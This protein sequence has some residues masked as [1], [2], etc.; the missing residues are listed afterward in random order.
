MKFNITKI[1]HD[2]QHNQTWLN[3]CFVM[4]STLYS[5]DNDTQHNDTLHSKIHATI[6]KIR[7][8][9]QFNSA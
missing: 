9:E 2:T 8:S 6:N 3:D 7:H 1:K 5:E 4:L